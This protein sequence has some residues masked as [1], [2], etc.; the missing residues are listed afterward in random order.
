MRMDRKQTR[1][2]RCVYRFVKKVPGGRVVTYA[3]VACRAGFPR[4][5]R[6][7]GNALN[8]S[9]GMPRVPCHRVVCSDGRVGGYAGGV[10]KK[11]AMLRREGVI[12]ERG[13]IDLKQFG[14]RGK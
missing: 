10:R 5:A 11:V 14:W 3:Q 6:A 13:K 7:A 8:K 1:F 2:C 4:A 9:P 12:I